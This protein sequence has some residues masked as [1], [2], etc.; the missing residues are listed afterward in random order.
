MWRITGCGRVLIQVDS[1]EFF[2]RADVKMLVLFYL[3]MPVPAIGFLE[4]N[5]KASL[6]TRI[7][8]QI[9]TSL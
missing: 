1:S 3:L 2:A 5:E 4:V 9:E 8:H 7:H 6:D